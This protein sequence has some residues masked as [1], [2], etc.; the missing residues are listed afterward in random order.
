MKDYVLACLTGLMS[1]LVIND[2]DTDVPAKV[3]KL[4]FQIA[5]ECVK[6]EARHERP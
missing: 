6:R 3:A 2:A 5:E 4:A 1:R